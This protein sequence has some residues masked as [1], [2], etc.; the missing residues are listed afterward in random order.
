MNNI[1]NLLSQTF[2]PH[3]SIKLLFDLPEG[4]IKLEFYGREV[5]QVKLLKLINTPVSIGW[6]KWNI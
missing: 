6:S 4:F 1:Q 2:S 3:T 5:F